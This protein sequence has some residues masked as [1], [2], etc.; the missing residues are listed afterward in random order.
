VINDPGDLGCK[1]GLEHL[2]E[3]AAKARRFSRAVRLHIISIRSPH[4]LHTM[5]VQSVLKPGWQVGRG[6]VWGMNTGRSKAWPLGHCSFLLV[7]PR[8]S[9]YLLLDRVSEPLSMHV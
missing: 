2:D 4:H 7:S 1:R 8:I 6:R 5:P 3:L 9:S